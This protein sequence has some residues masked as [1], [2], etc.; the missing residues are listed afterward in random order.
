MAVVPPPLLDAPLASRSSQ[1]R[2]AKGWREDIRGGMSGD[3]FF[4]SAGSAVVSLPTTRGG[5]KGGGSLT[6]DADF[7]PP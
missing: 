2:A 5:I 1:P 3:I 4:G 7:S 6:I